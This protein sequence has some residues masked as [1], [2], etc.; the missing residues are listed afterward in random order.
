MNSGE[1]FGGLAVPINQSVAVK[2]P[3]GSGNTIQSYVPSII[4]DLTDFIDDYAHNQMITYKIGSNSTSGIS[5][6][7]RLTGAIIR[8]ANAPTI[9]SG[10]SYQT[11]SNI[12]ASSP[13]ILGSD[14][15]LYFNSDNS[16]SP[17]L[18]KVSQSTL[19]VVASFGKED[20]H[21]DYNSN[22]MQLLHSGVSLKVGGKNYLVTAGLA[23]KTLGVIDIDNMSYAGHNVGYAEAAAGQLCLGENVKAGSRSY[24]VAYSI[25][26]PGAFSST[27]A[28]IYRTV[29]TANAANFYVSPHLVDAVPVSG[30]ITTTRIG[31]IAPSDVDATWTNFTIFI[32][33]A[34]DITDGNIL[35]MAQGNGASPC[36][37]MKIS[38]ATG[39]II[40]KTPIAFIPSLDGMYFANSTIK[41]SKVAILSE[42]SNSIY[43]FDT[44][45]GALTTLSSPPSIIN[46]FVNTSND[47]DGSYSSYGTWSG[48]T[49][50]G[51]NGTAAFANK[52]FVVRGTTGFPGQVTDTISGAIPAVI[53]FT[54]TSQ[55]QLL[56]PVAPQETGARNGPAFGKTR[57]YH[58]YIT[59]VA[60][61][62]GIQ[63]GTDFA[64]VGNVL[65]RPARF[66]SRGGKGALLLSAAVLYAGEHSDTVDDDYDLDGMLCWQITRPYP[67]TVTALGGMLQ[68]QDR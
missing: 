38:A 13:I 2:Y 35:A 39:T 23:F 47:I 64:G 60:N 41:Y 22:H 45:S 36:Y 16:N 8:E 12:V 65:M 5:I 6:Y 7:N 63:F 19:K 1:D 49:L 51:V 44:T 31:Q 66:K 18:R 48:A 27:P 68:T 9:F 20:S 55:G 32:G 50:V 11:S 24:G 57:R 10:T 43:V 25:S 52:A 21:G 62:G 33:P 3:V 30:G 42:G 67:G 17:V 26:C 53:G 29:I 15:F 28:G 40:W 14:G 46:D 34:Y 58:R 59:A 61:T 37:V 54:Y 56:R 4:S